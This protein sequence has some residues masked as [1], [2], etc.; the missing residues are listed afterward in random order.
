MSKASASTEEIHKAVFDFLCAFAIVF[1]NDWS[2]TL[3][4]IKDDFS[5]ETDATFLHP[6]V[7]DESNNWGNRGSLLSSFRKL[8]D[9]LS[10]TETHLF[11]MVL[12]SGVSSLKASSMAD[13]QEAYWRDLAASQQETIAGLTRLLAAAQK[14]T[15]PART[16]G[17]GATKTA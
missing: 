10:I 3:S 5:G 14:P 15:A 6:N 7:A 1:D 17:H 12:N 4:K 8:L 11:S 9:V 2:F 16:G 13:V